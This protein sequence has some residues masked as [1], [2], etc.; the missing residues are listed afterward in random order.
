MKICVVVVV[1][2]AP[3]PASPLSTPKASAKLKASV[4]SRVTEITST[5]KRWFTVKER[6]RSGP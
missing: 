6:Y 4:E 3:A 5:V 2:A 1:A